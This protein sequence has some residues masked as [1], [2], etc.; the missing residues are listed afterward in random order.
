MTTRILCT[1]DLHLGRRP[2]Q[3]AGRA[4]ATAF[5]P[6]AAW[7]AFVDTA[8]DRQVDLVA[9]TG[10]LVDESNKFYEAFSAL[11]A[12]VRRLVEAGVAVVGVAGNHDHDVLPRLARAIPGFRLLGAGGRWQHFLY[13]RAGV[14]LLCLQGWSFP[15][16]RVSDTPLAGYPPPPDGVPTIALLHCDCDLAESVYAPVR[17]ADLQGRGPLAWVL[18]HIHNPRVFSETD[19]LVLY[20]GSLQGLHPGE[21]GGHAAVLLTLEP[22]GLLTKEH[23]PLCPLRWET[24]PVDLE[25]VGDDEG[26]QRAVT[27]A[28]RQRHESLRGELGRTRLVACRL[29]LTG[30]TPVHRALPALLPV[31]QSDL[32]LTFEGEVE[33]CLQSVEDETRPGLALEDLARATDPAGLLARRLLLLES[34]QPAEDYR[35]LLARGGRRLQEVAAYGQFAALQGGLPADGEEHVRELLLQAGW[36]AL[37][38]LLAQK[39]GLP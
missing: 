7:Q 24:V 6:A 27:E 34:R 22:G 33:Y 39:G 5:G 16:R 12:G 32:H 17:L 1:G 8:L 21:P 37:E 2:R 11:S 19:P 23:L 15:A 25:G 3:L 35:A 28:L 26:L 10:D 13:E 20:L 30:R 38:A 31:L 36:Q 4:D 29:R 14:P 18:G 9:L